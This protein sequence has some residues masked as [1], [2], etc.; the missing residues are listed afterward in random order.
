MK[1]NMSMWTLAA[2]A[3]TAVVL[4]GCATESNSG[5]FVN[6]APHAKPGSSDYVAPAKVAATKTAEPKTAEPKTAEPAP[7]P[8]KAE[9]PKADPF[10][11]AAT[12][13]TAM[14]I[15]TGDRSTSALMIEKIYPSQVTVGQPFDYIIKATNIS[16]QALNNVTVTEAAPTNFNLVSSSVQGANGVYNLGTL[17]AG[18]SK[19]IVMKGSAAAVGSINSCCAA[20]YTTALCSTIN[21][22][23]PA[24][25]INKT[26]T[27]EAILNCSPINMTVVVKNTGSGTA[28]NVHVMDTLPSGLTFEGGGA[29]F[30]EAVGDLA[31]GAEK[32]ISK[33][34]K[35]A[36]VG[37]YEN[38]AS[39]KADGV[40]TIASNK[41]STVVKAPKLEVSCKAGGKVLMGRKACYEI[42][43][44]N[45]G[46]AVSAGT[47]VSLT[48]PAG[49][50][51]ASMSDGGAAGVFNVGDLAAGASKTMTV[52]LTSTTAGSLPVSA[53]A[54]GNCAQAAN[55]NCSIDVIGAP[56]IGTQ[57]TDDNGVVDMGA[58]HTFRYEVKNQGW[59]DLTNVSVAFVL[60][61]GLDMVRCDAAGGAQG[62]GRNFTVKV[63]TLKVG[64]TVKFNIVAKGSKE[65]ELVIQS[66]TTSDQTKSVRND[67]Q[68]NYIK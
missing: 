28:S 43:V 14:Y 32:T 1:V 44:K 18:E 47:K 63:G 25:A 10:A 45:S 58:E 61:E 11:K 67:E 37:K 50:T 57:I 3:G 51:V 15:P 4:G 7:A 54:T 30:D 42:T 62:S 17:N 23:Q 16:S 31:P 53:V 66:T 5:A 48:L 39:A 19:M 41:V 46:D 36:N 34:I 12:S 60:E 65:G 64:Q 59:V 9:A 26:I 13:G 8:K 2:V 56:D 55:T 22:V 49:A 24:L 20:T 6:T 40:G 29:S 52:C 38:T 21:V 33:A 27:P 35:A 68:V